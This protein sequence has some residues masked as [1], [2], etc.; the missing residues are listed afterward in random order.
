MQNKKLIMAITLIACLAIG[1]FAI[2][3]KAAET[4]IY[5][6]STVGLTSG[7]DNPSNPEEVSSVHCRIRIYKGTD[8][9]MD[10]Y[11]SGVVTDLG[12]NVTIAK[13][14]GDG[15]YNLTQY[16]MNA[17]FI[18]IGNYSSIDSTATILPSEW[19][20][21]AGTVED[22][23][24]S[25]LN[26]TATIYPDAS[27]PYIADCIGLNLEGTIG[28]PQSLWAYDTFTEVTGIDESFTI[29][30]EFSISVSHS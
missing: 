4:T 2:G 11:H 8:L 7:I 5:I 3:Y 20:R 28:T 25:T 9:I 24:A 23:G 13:L 14:F 10:Q 12:D 19:N 21:T 22:E 15:D 30:I 29:N 18:S 26:I 6:E 17:T 27:G 1:F 16:D